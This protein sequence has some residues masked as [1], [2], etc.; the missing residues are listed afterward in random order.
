MSTAI[1]L[2]SLVHGYA[3][4]HRDGQLTGLPSQAMPDTARIIASL[5]PEG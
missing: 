2:W 1:A 5:L 4:L 3:T